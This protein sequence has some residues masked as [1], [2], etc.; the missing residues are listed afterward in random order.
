VALTLALA[1]CG[2][3]MQV[4]GEGD[5]APEI[6]KARAQGDDRSQCDFRGRDDREV[7][8]SSGPGAFQPNVRRVYRILGEGD[9]RRKVL[10][11]REVD[12]NLDGVKDL[13]RRYDDKGE[14]K[15]ELADS[16][17]DGKIDS[18]IQYAGGRISKV[19][20]DENSDGKADETRYYVRGKLSRAQRDS[21]HDGKPDI[22]EI[23]ASGRLERMGFD[24][25]F[26]GRV[27]R[28]DRDEVARRDAELKERAEEEKARKEA[29]EKQ[30]QEEEQAE[31]Q[32]EPA[33]EGYVSPRR[34]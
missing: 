17:Y 26:D 8:E 13:V 3:G 18:W 21:N 27:D 16:I 20:T 4:Q 25:D 2:G 10:V 31:G 19:E 34:R 28:W 24:V 22:W 1:G 11:C 15:E 23:Y 7:T 14:V 12:T 33:K 30:R 32:G 5:M 29:E 9:A 6:A